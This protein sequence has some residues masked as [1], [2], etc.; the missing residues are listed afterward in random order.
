M[1]V[2]DRVV[3]VAVKGS[4]ACDNAEILVEMA[5]AGLGLV[6]LGSFLMEEALA[7]GRLVSLMTDV[8]VS[9]PMPIS[10]IMPPGRQNL[11]RVR[12]FLDFLTHPPKELAR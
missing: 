3:P 4:A 7:D 9:E 1:R 11:P 12:A 6:R 10:A 8:H 2:D 5:L